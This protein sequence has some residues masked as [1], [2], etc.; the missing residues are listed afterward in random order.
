M[1]RR[2]RK[3]TAVGK[4]IAQLG[5]QVDIAKALGICQQSV[6][7]KL[8]GDNA[9]LLSDLERLAKKFKRPLCWFVMSEEDCSIAERHASA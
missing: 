8:R 3:Y 7:K 9:I 4:R 2:H 5:R 6:S 1:K